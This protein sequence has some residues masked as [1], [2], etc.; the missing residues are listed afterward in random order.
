MTRWYV[1]RGARLDYYD[2]RGGSILGSVNIAGAQ[3]GRQQKSSVVDTDENSYRHA[4]LLLEKRVVGGPSAPSV[5]SVTSAAAQSSST[6]TGS[7]LGGDAQ[8]VRHVLCAQ[9]DPERDEWVDVLVRAVAEIDRT[10]RKSLGSHHANDSNARSE[11]PQG[12]SKRSNSASNR[13]RKDSKDA[14]SQKVGSGSREESSEPTSVPHHKSSSSSVGNEQQQQYSSNDAGGSGIPPPGPSSPPPS[15]RFGGVKSSQDQG[16]PSL[17]V[18]DRPSTPDG[19]GPTSSTG[20]GNRASV[21]PAISGPMNGTPIPTGY[22]FG[23]KDSDSS[24]DASNAASSG[25]GSGGG[26]GK[27]E[28]ADKKGFWAFR[29]FRGN[30]K[31]S[32]PR[33]EPRPVFGVPLAESIAISSIAEGLELPSVVFRCIEY[34]E[35]KEA[36]KEEGIYRLS[37]STAVI[38][39]LKERFNNEGDVDLLAADHEYDPHAIAGL[40]KTFLRE[41]PTSVLTRELHLDFMRV[42]GEYT[43]GSLIDA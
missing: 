23:A 36:A 13:L 3:L 5:S 33:H 10:E 42:N 2:T 14:S 1:L 17:S 31:T 9:S 25:S 20:S 15:A 16:R 35:K 29:G 38:K 11:Q 8:T 7:G 19:S 34:L 41:L 22:K 32:A 28:A 26:A 30:D 39:G 27:K 4:F 40:L 24:T 43:I 12:R 37:G 18:T 21:R 6:T